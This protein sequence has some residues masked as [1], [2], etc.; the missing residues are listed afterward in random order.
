MFTSEFIKKIKFLAIYILIYTAIFVLI[1]STIKYTMPFILAFLIALWIKPVTGFI[2]KKLKLNN[3]ISSLMS[4]IL[5]FLFLTFI[6]TSI[7]YKTSN[8]VK[9][10]IN[11]LP[12]I[13]TITNYGFSYFKQIKL[14]LNKVNPDIINKVQGSISS[15][16][17]KTSLFLGDALKKSITVA[18][19]LPVLFADIFITFMATYFISKD[20]DNL[21][22]RFISIFSDKARQ[23][24]LAIIDEAKKMFIGYIRAYSFV[25]FL[26]FIE[27]LIGFIFLKIKFA[28]LLSIISA[29]LDVL[30]ILGIG[31]V[32]F[33]IAIVLFI[34]KHY[35]TAVCVII[36]YI[37][38]SGLRQIIEPKVVSASLGL[39]PLSVLAAIF[40]GIAAD[41]FTGMLY[42]IF[43]LVFYKILKNSKIF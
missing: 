2:R 30:P 16:I 36:L 3:S 38:V 6:L 33:S 37:V 15:F 19:K 20:L 12:G 18:V 26:T 27:T 25:I 29:I 8:E 21:E 43:L 11:T 10:L 24:V 35:F 28:L 7:I 1:F 17:A 23:K 34:G 5:F 32:Y 14:Y 40:I 22:C 41:G 13:N 42:F 4:T 39:S 31:L 9:D